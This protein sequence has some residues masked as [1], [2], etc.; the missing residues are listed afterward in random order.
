MTASA[1]STMS[2]R[3]PDDWPDQLVSLLDRQGRVCRELQALASEQGN[4]IKSDRADELVALLGARQ[5]LIDELTSLSESLEPYRLRWAELLA[6][7]DFGLR[8]R[9]ERSI[10]DAQ[11]L[12][13]SIVEGDRRDQSR[14]V[15]EQARLRQRLD[16]LNTGKKS[17]RAYGRGAAP[18]PQRTNRFMDEKG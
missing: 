7:L 8:A 9:V 17:N 11:A 4:L 12:V 1:S 15:E 16:T 18:G 13:D 3:L 6:R 2:P 14:L 5:A 10:A